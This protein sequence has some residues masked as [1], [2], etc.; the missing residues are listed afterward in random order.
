MRAIKIHSKYLLQRVNIGNGKI[1]FQRLELILG[2][3]DVGG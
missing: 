1:A 3:T 2:T